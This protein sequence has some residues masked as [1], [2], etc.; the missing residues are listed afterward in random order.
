MKKF[1]GMMLP[2][3]VC[4]DDGANGDCGA[5]AF[6]VHG[7][8]RDD[9]VLYAVVRIG[10][11][12]MV[13]RA[14]SGQQDQR[15]GGVHEGHSPGARDGRVEEAKAGKRHGEHGQHNVQPEHPAVIHRVAADREV[16]RRQS[17]QQERAA[18]PGIA[19]GPHRG[20]HHQG[21][22]ESQ[23]QQ[24]VAHVEDGGLGERGDIAAVYNQYPQTDARGAFTH[25][26]NVHMIRPP[27]APVAV[28]WVA[29]ES[30]SI[31]RHSRCVF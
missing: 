30:C 23:V 6:L 5:G 4:A 2:V 13:E 17:R 10:P 18:H 22:A 25:D 26:D 19:A 16:D 15:G 21:Q 14:G 24:D 8:G 20:A 28:A 7:D 11:R 31:W 3:L 12:A 29:V 1:D 9:G 27:V